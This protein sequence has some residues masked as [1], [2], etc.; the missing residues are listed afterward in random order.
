M[1]RDRRAETD[2]E[3]DRQEREYTAI[4]SMTESSGQLSSNLDC[5]VRQSQVGGRVWT[6]V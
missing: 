3:T 6:D 5:S 4:T 1:R 2:M